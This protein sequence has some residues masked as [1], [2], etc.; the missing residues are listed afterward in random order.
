MVLGGVFSGRF[1]EMGAA[2]LGVVGYGVLVNLVAVPASLAQ[3]PRVA[4]VSI[5]IRGV[6]VCLIGAVVSLL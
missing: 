1:L 2:A 5:V 3:S 4:R 6:A